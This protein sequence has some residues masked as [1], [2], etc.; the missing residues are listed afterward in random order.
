MQRTNIFLEARQTEA[1][2]RLAAGEGIS[3]AELIRRLLDRA[4]GGLG[5]DHD[6]LLAAIDASAGSAAG[7]AYPRRDG[8]ARDEHL[9]H[10]WDTAP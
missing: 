10:L 7:L 4:L 3:R 2:D 8:S 6:R 5:S 1:L 9:K